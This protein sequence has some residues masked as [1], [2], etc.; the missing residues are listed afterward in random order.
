MTYLV[1]GVA[2]FFSLLCE[3][4]LASCHHSA[5]IVKTAAG[6]YY[7]ALVGLN[8][9]P[10]VV[11]KGRADD[12]SCRPRS[13]ASILVRSAS[14]DLLFA[15]RYSHLSCILGFKNLKDKNLAQFVSRS[16][17]SFTLS[18]FRN[19]YCQIDS[20]TQTASVH[21]GFHKSNH[22]YRS[23]FRRRLS[24]FRESPGHQLPSNLLDWY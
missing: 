2:R 15:S 11:L 18:S 24:V 23:A 8:G 9:D 4:F 3:T 20:S 12:H 17:K 1:A 16:L 10:F 13:A 22:C 5:G 21:N 19:L 7:S 6:F 14:L